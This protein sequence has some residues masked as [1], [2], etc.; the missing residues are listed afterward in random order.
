MGRFEG[1]VVIV[2]GAASGVGRATS[3][4]MLDGGAQVFGVDVDAEGLDA[5]ASELDAEFTAGVYDIRTREACHDA[6]SAAV[7]TYGGLDVLAN[8]AGVARSHHVADVDEDVWALI[9]DV[10]VTGMFWMTQAAIPH[11]LERG[12]NVVNV[13]SNAGLMGQ[14]YMV[15]YCASKGAV[16]NMTKALAMEFVKSSVRINCVA[17]GGMATSLTQDFRLPDDISWDL[18]TPYAGFRG[19]AEP[20]TAANAICWLASNDAERCTG[21]ILSVDGGLSAG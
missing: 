3:R 11:L 18:V 10:N 14:A 2:T 4:Q 5:L 6:V 16:V 19:M 13:A 17:P 8:V 20:E 12:G 7:H 21:T 9:M 1:K 15:P